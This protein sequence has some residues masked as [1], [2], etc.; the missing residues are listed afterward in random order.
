MTPTTTSTLSGSGVRSG[1][2]SGI[3]SGIIVAGI[4]SG[5]RILDTG[6]RRLALV[7]ADDEL[8]A[9]ITALRRGDL[10][11]VVGEERPDR[12]TPCG[13]AFEVTALAPTSGTSRS[14]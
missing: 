14:I 12:E 10:V 9:A 3:R 13:A 7:G 8:R 6:D 2:R 4:R 5:C 1:V 11:T